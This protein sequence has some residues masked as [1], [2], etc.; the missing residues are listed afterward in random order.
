MTFTRTK[1]VEKSSYYNRK[2]S[3]YRQKWVSKK[4]DWAKVLKPKSKQHKDIVQLKW[5]QIKDIAMQV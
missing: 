4:A 2:F 3:D 5:R 1:N